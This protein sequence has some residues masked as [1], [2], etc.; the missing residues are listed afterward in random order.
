MRVCK[1]FCDCGRVGTPPMRRFQRWRPSGRIGSA[2]RR[3]AGYGGL[4]RVA[5]WSR[6]LL[7][8]GGLPVGVWHEWRLA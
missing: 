3:A 5:G 8:V 7:D 1:E 4:D 6:P 2:S